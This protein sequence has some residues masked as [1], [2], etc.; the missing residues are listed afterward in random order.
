MGC[1][2]V[3]ATPIGNLEDITARALK[4]LQSV[5]WI[6]AED[7]RHTQNLLQHF[8]IKQ[9]LLSLHNW[10]EDKRAAEIIKLLKNG[11]SVA[12]VSDAGTPLI[13]DP[14][15]PLVLQVQSVGLKIVPI[16]GPCALITALSVS[17]LP[18]HQ[19]IFEG[20]LPAKGEK[21]RKRLQQLAT[22]PRTIVLYESCHRIVL[23]L[24]ELVEFFGAERQI[25]LARELTKTYET[26]LFSTADKL[27]QILESEDA[28][29][30]GEFVVVIG[31]YT[32]VA[33][34]NWLE[35]ERVLQVLLK[36]LPVKQAVSLARELTGASRQQLYQRALELQTKR[37]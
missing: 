22:E 11:E 33:T 10:N 35:G 25:C 1:L 26:L 4:V 36:E 16:P 7:T 6:A 21:R 5:D 28:Q 12:L 17:G 31:G 24:T 23:L 9:R 2:Y 30:K 18:T 15:F 13:S 29:R 34:D 32:E 20:F 27:L 14:G 3:V 37:N 8:G 19:F